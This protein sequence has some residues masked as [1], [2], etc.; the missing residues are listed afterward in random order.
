MLS[1]ICGTFHPLESLY[2]K[3]CGPPLWNEGLD[4]NLRMSAFSSPNEITWRVNWCN[5]SSELS[6]DVLLKAVKGCPSNNLVHWVDIIKGAEWLSHDYMEASHVSVHSTVE[7]FFFV[8]FWQCRKQSHFPERHPGVCSK[9]YSECIGSVKEGNTQTNLIRI[10]RN[11]NVMF[12][13]H[14]LLE[15]WPL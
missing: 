4:W 10:S 8:F 5:K 12:I 2:L 3:V 15:L 1:R 9:V 7:V 11:F 13:L 6:R 14:M